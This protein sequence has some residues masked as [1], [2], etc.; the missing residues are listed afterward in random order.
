[1]WRFFFV[2][3]F[4]AFFLDFLNQPLPFSSCETST[5]SV[6]STSFTSDKYSFTASSSTVVLRLSKLSSSLVFNSAFVARFLLSMPICRRL[7]VGLVI[8]FFTTG[9]LT[10][11]VVFF[12]PPFVTVR[13]VVEGR[14]GVLRW[15]PSIDR[16]LLIPIF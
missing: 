15:R 10:V 5:R 7:A 9:F 13:L 11:V 6:G 2:F 16:L 4:L 12:T 1:M 14:A 8:T 3:S